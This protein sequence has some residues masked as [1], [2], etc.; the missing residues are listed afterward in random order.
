[1]PFCNF[2]AKIF[3]ELSL[4]SLPTIFGI[5]LLFV[6]LQMITL[7]SSCDWDWDCVDTHRLL[8]TITLL[9]F[10]LLLSLSFLRCETSVMVS[11]SSSSPPSV[12][13]LAVVA[14]AESVVVVSAAAVV[15]PAIHEQLRFCTFCAN[16]SQC[17]L[18][19]CTPSTNGC[20]LSESTPKAYQSKSWKK[21]SQRKLNTQNSIFHFC[22]AHNKSN[23]SSSTNGRHSTSKFICSVFPFAFHLCHVSITKI[24]WKKRWIKKDGYK[25]ADLLAFGACYCCWSR[26]SIHSIQ[27][28]VYV[29]RKSV[30]K[31]CRW[32]S[33]ASLV[34]VPLSLYS[35]CP[36]LSLKNDDSAEWKQQNH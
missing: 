16:S 8:F 29:P 25:R 27:Y 11:S 1:M 21:L 2:G 7:L 35:L 32:N 10:K 31:W 20:S 28:R 3:C 15:G 30:N 23:N 33:L 12:I 5:S 18:F 19:C 9:L 36:I 17:S 4:P 22:S 13:L 6:P 24:L 26:Y 34:T 14:G